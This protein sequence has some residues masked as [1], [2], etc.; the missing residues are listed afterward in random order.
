[1]QSRRRRLG[2]RSDDGIAVVELAI[3]L[4]ILVLL[5]LATVE[6]CVMLQLKQNVTVTAYEG[7]RIGI[8]P[9]AEATN[10]Q[11]QCELLLGDRDI[12]GY[13]ITMN[14]DPGIVETGEMFSV[15]VS[16]DCV[17]NSVLGGVFYQGNTISE[18]V[19]MR[20]E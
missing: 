2:R 20:A 11:M 14:P 10:V 19:I 8:L 1:M 17:A 13:T 7:A 12:D 16:A 4:P 15:T 18:T 6:A 3:C 9:G 5:L